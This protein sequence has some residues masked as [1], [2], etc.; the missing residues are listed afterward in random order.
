MCSS[1]HLRHTKVTLHITACST[2]DI[3]TRYKVEYY[4]LEVDVLLTHMNKR[5]G[6]GT[7]WP[8]NLSDKQKK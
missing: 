4:T 8:C 3:T 1:T 7:K 6:A 5:V 2:L